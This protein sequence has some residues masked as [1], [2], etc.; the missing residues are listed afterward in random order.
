LR[1]TLA[2]GLIKQGETYNTVSAVLG[3]VHSSSADVYTHI[4]INGLLGCA[5][6]K[7]EVTAYV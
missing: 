1:H 7:S 2:S 4:D 5:L 6:E 3:H